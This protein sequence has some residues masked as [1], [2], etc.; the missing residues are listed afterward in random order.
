MSMEKNVDEILQNIKE[1]CEKSNRSQDEITL[2]AVTKTVDVD[3]MIEARKL[4]L[5]NFGENKPQELVR[6]FDFFDEEIRWHMIG[7]LQRN[8]VKYIIDKVE[9]IHSLDN[10]K[11]AEEIQKQS[12][13]HDKVMDV[14]IEINIGNEISKH[15]ISPDEL[16]DFVDKVKEL[17]NIRIKGLMTVAP[18]M[19][20]AEEVRPYMKKMKSLFD[21]LKAI[22]GDCIDTLSMGMSNDYKIAIEEGATM[23]RIGSS[24]FGERIY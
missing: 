3:A 4:D 15:G 6:K 20:D 18:Y 22:E 8:K 17:K 11:L 9:L 2:I 12:V 10:M 23:V 1:A 19:I 14:L 7:H 24:I 21:Q 13:K 5:K 16:F